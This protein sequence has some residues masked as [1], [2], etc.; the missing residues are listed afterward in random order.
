M[1]Y[2]YAGSWQS[3]VDYHSPWA[4]S[5]VSGSQYVPVLPCD[6]LQ[7][8]DYLG[9]AKSGTSA[10]PPARPPSCLPACEASGWAWLA[11]LHQ[12]HE[13]PELSNDLQ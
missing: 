4:G 1:T 3:T 12:E 11:L 13:V 9:V 2:D 7:A 6:W 5:N 10:R 8:V